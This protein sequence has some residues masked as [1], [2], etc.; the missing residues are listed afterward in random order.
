MT[1]DTQVPVVYHFTTE[2][3]AAQ[4]NLYFAGQESQLKSRDDVLQ[5][6]LQLLP[7]FKKKVNKELEEKNRMLSENKGLLQLYKVRICK[8]VLL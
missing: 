7:K 6:L 4:S 5:L 3:I 2:K 8:F 1:L